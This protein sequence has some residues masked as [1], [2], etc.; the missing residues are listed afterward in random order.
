[1]GSDAT[2]VPCCAHVSSH[3]RSARARSLYVDTPSCAL[4]TTAR[5]P[6]SAR[7]ARYTTTV[8]N[9]LI[10]SDVDEVRDGEIYA[11]DSWSVALTR[12]DDHVYTYMFFPILNLF[13][14]S[15]LQ[16]LHRRVCH[17]S[18]TKLFNH[19]KR[20][21]PKDFTPD[22]LK[23][24]HEKAQAC[25]PCQRIKDGPGRFRVSFGDRTSWV[26]GGLVLDI[27]YIDRE[28]NTAH[29]RRVCTLQ[30][31]AFPVGCLDEKSMVMTIV[32]R[33][34]DC[35]ASAYIRPPN[36]IRV[37]LWENGRV[38]VSVIRIRTKGPSQSPLWS[39][40]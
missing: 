1:M 38:P 17:P 2:R 23:T 30:W 24:I 9:R 5:L 33:I 27:T 21:R 36:F 26:N 40:L 13:T 6:T 16:K 22:T 39:A 12:S 37:D 3:D 25:D 34:L 32:A 11:V 15:Q 4:C 10:K 20:G 31:S 28:A 7:V 18:A 35:S 29:C 14:K 8:K 19:L